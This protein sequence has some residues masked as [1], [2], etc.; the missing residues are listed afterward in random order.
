M[1]RNL[2]SLKTPVDVCSIS[3]DYNGPLRNTLSDQLLGKNDKNILHN[4]KK[5]GQSFRISNP[6]L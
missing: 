1:S 3:R 6:P 4:K 2:G 5:R